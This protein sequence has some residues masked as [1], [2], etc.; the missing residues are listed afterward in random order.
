MNVVT[1]SG[2]HIHHFVW[3]IFTLLLMGFLALSLNQPRWHPLL[4][5]VYGIG[6]ALVLDEF[7]LWLNL[8]DVYWA[9]EGRSSLDVVIVFATLVGLYLAAYRFWRGVIRE[10]RLTVIALLADLRLRPD[11]R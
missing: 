2:H 9:K 10:I 8:E 1:S 3:G 4:A 11:K 7:A 5:I 6:A